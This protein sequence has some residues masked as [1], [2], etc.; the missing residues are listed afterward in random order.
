MIYL[1]VLGIRLFGALFAAIF[2]TY[3][4]YFLMTLPTFYASY[5][6][7]IFYEPM[8]FGNFLIINDIK[9]EFI[10][11]CIAASAYVLFAIL[12]LLTKDIKFYKGL[13][14]LLLGS[15]IL[16]FVNIIRIFIL[17]VALIE[18]DKRWFDTLHLFFW[19]IF[20]TI[21]VV[22]TWIY[23]TKKFKVKTIPVYSDFM[24]LRKIIEVK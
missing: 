21:F 10:P 5:L 1:K 16:F 18:F 7:L 13:K 20:S 9:M 24:H 11:A 2:G 14:M 17:A 19:Q 15:L 6:S 12:I 8:I 4:V 22:L 3:I 23:L